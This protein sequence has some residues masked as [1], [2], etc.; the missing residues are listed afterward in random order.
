MDLTGS[1]EQRWKAVRKAIRA[2]LLRRV[3]GAHRESGPPR[4][5][6][7]VEPYYLTM[8]RNNADPRW[9]FPRS[10]FAICCDCLGDGRASL[11]FA[12]GGRTPASACLLIHDYDT[13][14]YHFSGSDDT[15]HE[16][17]PNNLLVFEAATWAQSRGYRRFHLGGGV[18]SSP[19]DS[20]V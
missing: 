1:E 6:S 20:R 15:F 18:S 5:T 3:S 9:F 13:A 11:F 17:C 7:T 8:E 12:Y 2:A 14:Y 16:F 10:Y 19:Q 4:R